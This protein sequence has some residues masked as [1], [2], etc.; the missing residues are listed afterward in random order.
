LR[1]SA[2]LGCRAVRQEVTY[3]TKPQRRVKG[4]EE[5]PDRGSFK[6]LGVARSQDAPPAGGGLLPGGNLPLAPGTAPVPGI[7]P[8]PRLRLPELGALP[9]AMSNALLVSGANSASGHP[10]AVFGP[11]VSYFAPQILMEEDL[12]GPGIDAKGAAFPGVNLY[13][14]LGHGR[15]YAWS[16][17]SAGQDIIDTF[18]VA[19]CD[20]THYRFRGQCLPIE[21]LERK[22]AWTPNLADSTPAGSETLHAERTKLGLVAGRGTY[23]RC[24]TASSRCA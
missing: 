21:V 15:D 2:P 8:L 19:L 1:C 11:Q 5:P 23:N 12:H 22:N 18:A 7:A 16:P 10:L 9:K 14:Q 24:S 4:A 3:Q 17:T 13:V 20:A 6:A